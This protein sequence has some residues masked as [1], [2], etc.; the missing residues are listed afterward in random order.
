MT[1]RLLSTMIWSLLGFPLA[2]SVQAQDASALRL[3]PFPKDVRLVKGSFV[4]NRSLT[5][6]LPAEPAPLL[7]RLLDD[8]LERLRL[9]RPQV[10]PRDDLQHALRWSAAT[11]G[12]P[13]QSAFRPDATPEDYVLQ[14]T[15]DAVTADAPGPAGARSGREAAG[16]APGRAERHLLRRG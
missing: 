11:G 6:E 3:V 14:I 1:H 15:S 4:L 2:T 5:I 13:P 16:D 12:V 10:R 9:P 7:S 8:E